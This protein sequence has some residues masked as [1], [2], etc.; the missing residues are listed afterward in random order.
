MFGRL[1]QLVLLV[2][3]DLLL[4]EGEVFYAHMCII[5]LGTYICHACVA[6]PSLAVGDLGETTYRGSSE[7]LV[8]GLDDLHHN[9]CQPQQ[10]RCLFC[11]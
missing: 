6:N 3:I 7:C 10:L 4:P 8:P 9:P 11:Q 1:Q 2:V 5:Q